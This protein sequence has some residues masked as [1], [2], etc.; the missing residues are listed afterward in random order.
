MRIYTIFSVALLLAIGFMTGCDNTC[1]NEGETP[2]TTRPTVISTIPVDLA[3]GVAVNSNISATFSEAMDPATIT[4]STFTVVVTTPTVALTQAAVSVPGV[5]TYSGVV[6]TLNPTSNLAANTDYTATITT[7]AEDPAGNGLAV[8]TTWTFRTGALPDVTAPTVISTI[9]ANLATAVALN[10]NVT[11]TFS[12]AMSPATILALNTFTLKQGT[13][14]VPGAVTYVGTIAT[15]NPTNNLATDTEYTATITTSA[16]DAA[17]NHLA[18]SKVWTFTTGAALDLTAPTVILVYPADH[19]IEVA[20]NTVVTA[21]FSEPMDET[22]IGTTSFTVAG[23][24]GSVLYDA[25]SKV[26]TFTPASN[27]AASTL[28]SATITTAVRDLA[29]NALA[30]NKV[31]TFTTGNVLAPGAVPLGSA[32]TFGI[33]AT[34]SITNTGAATMINGDVSLNP[35]TSCGLLPVQVNGTIYIND[36][37]GVSAQAKLDLEAAY[38]FAKNLAPGTTISA[39]ADLGA[40]YPLSSG[41]I[42]P[43][44]YTSGSTMLVSTPLVL[45]AGGNANA[46]WVFQIGS[47]LTTSADVTLANGAQA[48]NVFWVPT[49]SATVGVGTIFHG[50]IVAGVSATGVTGATIN[51]RI[52]AGATGP[53]T[54]ALDTNT[55]N[56][57]AP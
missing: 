38:T 10:S 28:Y 41:G 39:G 22:T 20:R 37:G 3:R 52:L 50:T 12:E 44:T 54:I 30:V 53:G 49:A 16:E 47:S 13:T 19:A 17:G 7:G 48:K 33:M 51:G 1:N 18:V 21:T 6:A 56:V 55:V 32:A 31:W 40:L 9:P 15:F 11:A 27:L 8:N 4:T 36:V 24:T 29:G 34:S 42:P 25:I 5:V 45:N 23:V 46:V 43:G 57:P 14:P 35:G 26:A 2:D